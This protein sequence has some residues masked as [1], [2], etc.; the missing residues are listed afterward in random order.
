[1]TAYYLNLIDVLI[2]EIPD[3]VLLHKIYA[4]RHDHK[5]CQINVQTC[6][7]VQI[8]KCSVLWISKI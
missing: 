6:L 5:F 7:L 2:V 8:T 3:S 4:S 1:M